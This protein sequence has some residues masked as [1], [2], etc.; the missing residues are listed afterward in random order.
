[1]GGKSFLEIQE[2][3]NKKRKYCLDNN[4]LLLEIS[5]KD[6]DKIEDILKG[7]I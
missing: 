2:R 6:F 4:L 5:Y 3:D 1:M 7:V